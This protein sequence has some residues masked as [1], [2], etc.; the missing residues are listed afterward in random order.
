M[1]LYDW[2]EVYK[3]ARG[4]P[5]EVL[6]IIN[7][8]VYKE[9]PLNK[10]DPIYKYSHIDFSGNSFLIHADVLLASFHR[11]SLHDVGVY[12]AT[13]ATRSLA[14]YMITK[15]PTI[16]LLACPVNPFDY[17]TDTRLLRL[18]GENKIHFLYEEVNPKEIH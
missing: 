14:N 16:D 13:S 5:S 11:H 2:G 10:K 17:I 1:F 4:K 15:D 12:I 8:L 6:R 18:D 9:I 3:A 7:M